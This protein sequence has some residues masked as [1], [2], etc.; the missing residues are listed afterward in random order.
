M[1]GP[2]VMYTINALVLLPAALAFM[3]AK[4]A[5]LTLYALIPF[6][7]LAYLINRAGRKIHT[8]FIKVQESYSDI[9]SH[10]QENLNG[11]QV[12]KAYA[13]RKEGDRKA[14]QSKRKI[15]G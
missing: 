12:I 3:F 7:F 13:S 6:P 11:I 14:P 5:Q 8:G 9:S 1:I 2:A 15:C 10:V 4:D